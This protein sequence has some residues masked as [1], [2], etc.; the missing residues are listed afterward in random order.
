MFE[1]KQKKT[2]QPNYFDK[3]NVKSGKQTAKNDCKKWLKAL[4][5]LISWAWINEI[6]GETTVCF[7]SKA[8]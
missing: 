6:F 4:Q 1:P 2:K 7:H 3:K 5:K 8:N